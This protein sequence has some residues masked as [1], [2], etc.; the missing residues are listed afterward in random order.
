MRTWLLFKA[1]SCCSRG[2]P[3]P[4]LR[5]LFFLKTQLPW[6]HSSFWEH[7]HP[8]DDS[9]RPKQDE[10]S[11]WPFWSP[12]IHG[13][14]YATC[15]IISHFK[16]ATTTILTQTITE[17]GITPP[18]KSIMQAITKKSQRANYVVIKIRMTSTT[19][20]DSQSIYTMRVEN[21]KRIFSNPQLKRIQIFPYYVRD[22]NRV[23]PLK[24]SL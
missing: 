9:F 2:H 11:N 21:W 1:S 3:S 18:V 23:L 22:Y 4:F 6:D 10:C 12:P 8:E 13:D 15:K 20:N 14:Y 24:S 19:K 5:S 16:R 7:C 17:E